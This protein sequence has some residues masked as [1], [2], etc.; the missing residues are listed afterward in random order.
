MNAVIDKFADISVELLR[1]MDKFDLLV[2]ALDEQSDE[3]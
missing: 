2:R 3:G 1:T